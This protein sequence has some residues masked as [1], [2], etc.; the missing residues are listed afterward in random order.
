MLWYWRLCSAPSW[1][2]WIL[3][4]LQEASPS[5]SYWPNPSFPMV[6]KQDLHTC[7]LLVHCNNLEVR[8]FILFC[9]VWV[10]CF[11]NTTLLTLSVFYGVLILFWSPMQVA[12]SKVFSEGVFSSIY[13][14]NFIDWVCPSTSPDTITMFHFLHNTSWHA[15]SREESRYVLYNSVLDLVKLIKLQIFGEKCFEQQCTDILQ[16]NIRSC[17]TVSLGRNI[18]WSFTMAGS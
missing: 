3:A 13:S 1:T 14:C 6:I 5:Q 4:T 12:G 10:G 9:F 15:N 11:W 17:T 18:K 8:F 2:G 7:S 16:C